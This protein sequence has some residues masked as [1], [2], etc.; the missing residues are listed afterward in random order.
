MDKSIVFPA[1]LYILSWAND[2]VFS[3][4][5]SKV[6]ACITLPL[7]NQQNGVKT[8]ILPLYAGSK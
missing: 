8:T 4:P 5:K 2:I 3:N 7:L 6:K 1:S